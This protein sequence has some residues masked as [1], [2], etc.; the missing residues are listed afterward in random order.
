MHVDEVIKKLGEHMEKVFEE[1]YDA[2]GWDIKNTSCK[3]VV[4]FEKLGKILAKN[5]SKKWN[6]TNFCRST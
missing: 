2:F 3:D 5:K 4:K 1:D 6:T